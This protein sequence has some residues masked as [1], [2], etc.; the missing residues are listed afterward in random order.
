MEYNINE[1]IDFNINHI[2]KESVVY[3]L[4]L[5]GIDNKILSDKMCFALLEKLTFESLIN[6][7]EKGKIHLLSRAYQVIKDGGWIKHL[8]I[9]KGNRV[10]ETNQPKKHFLEIASWVIGGVAAIIAIYE[11]IVK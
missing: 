2:D 9:E 11:F 7:D 4:E 8:E 6:I 10:K 1:L 5:R 3:K